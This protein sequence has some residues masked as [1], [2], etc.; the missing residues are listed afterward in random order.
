[1]KNDPAFAKE[2]RR[3]CNI[4]RTYYRG[5]D[6][7]LEMKE[8]IQSCCNRHRKPEDPPLYNPATG[9]VSEVFNTV[10]KDLK[11]E[12]PML[13]G[14]FTPKKWREFYLNWIQPKTVT[15][16]NDI[17]EDVRKK[18]ESV[19]FSRL[20][21]E[22]KVSHAKLSRQL[23]KEGH[24]YY[25]DGLIKNYIGS[26]LRRDAALASSNLGT[27]GM[28]STLSPF[29]LVFPEDVTVDDANLYAAVLEMFPVDV[30]TP[31]SP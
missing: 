20:E 28:D 2:V 5:S 14:S 10:L 29:A 19:A 9:R 3:I 4:K 11:K 15:S 16:I 24:G 1:M 17:P 8:K 23:Y 31:Q 7:L 13:F 26:C 6:E 18:I 12:D 30:S 21:G 25:T 27:S 22:K